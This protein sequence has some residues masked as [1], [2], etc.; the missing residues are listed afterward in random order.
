VGA[1]A[2][3][4]WNEG[5]VYLLLDR[6]FRGYQPH[7]KAGFAAMDLLCDMHVVGVG[8]PDTLN[9]ARA[10]GE[11]WLSQ[12]WPNGLF[13]KIPGEASDHLDANTDLSV[14]LHKLAF[15]TGDTRYRQAAERC[16]DAILVYHAGPAGYVLS[17]SR[18]GQVVDARVLVKYQSLL[19]KLAL[20]DGESPYDDTRVAGLLRDR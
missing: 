11:F 12:Q 7:L 15:L 18:E 10:I 16:R 17:V 4:L 13:P 8:R 20:L 6:R 2:H 5:N 3:W 14:A 9:L 1:F 19:L